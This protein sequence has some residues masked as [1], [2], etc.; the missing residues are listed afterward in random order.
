MHRVSLSSNDDF[1]SMNFVLADANIR[2]I[3]RQ[4]QRMRQSSLKL[5]S[6]LSRDD[7]FRH[8]LSQVESTQAR[9]IV[10]T[11]YWRISFYVIAMAVRLVH[12]SNLPSSSSFPQAFSAL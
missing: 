12:Q 1:H 11:T 4:I 7:L 6:I 3:D 10:S 9:Q 5:I 2:S 8:L